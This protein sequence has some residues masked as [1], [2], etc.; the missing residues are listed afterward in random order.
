MG[1]AN[2]SCSFTRFRI[3]DPVPDALWPQ[4]PDKLKQF[5]FRD[6]DDIPE[7]EAHGWVNFD[8]MLDTALFFPCG[9]ICDAFPPELSK[10]MWPWP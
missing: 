10:S 9:R 5:A 3:L 6:I 4:I 1:F 2:S 7:M 8:D